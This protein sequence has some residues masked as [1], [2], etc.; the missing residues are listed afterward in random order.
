[1]NKLQKALGIGI[2]ALTFGILGCREVKQGYS[3]IKYEEAV[4]SAMEYVPPEAVYQKMYPEQWNIKFEGHVNFHL[5]NEEIFKKFKKG[6]IADI[7]Y[8]GVYE[9]VYD[10]IDKDGKNELV[11]SRLKSYCV[12][13]A[14]PKGQFE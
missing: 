13:D 8:F 14:H 7:F 6:D 11:E 12:I 4:V 5:N 1:M 3:N 10:D 9:D 2:S